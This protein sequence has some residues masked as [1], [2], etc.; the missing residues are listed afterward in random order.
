MKH[1]DYREI[2]REIADL[3]AQLGGV[4][5]MADAAFERAHPNQDRRDFAM[6][7][8]GQL[9][10]LQRESAVARDREQASAQ[11]VAQ[12]GEPL[13][14]G[15][16]GGG[17]GFPTFR[18]ALLGNFT[19]A[20]TTGSDG[21]SLV[22]APLLAEIVDKA[23]ASDPINRLARRF[24]LSG[25]SSKMRLP[26]RT[27]NG[28][29]VRVAEEEARPVTT[30][31]TFIELELACFERYAHYRASRMWVESTPDAE[32]LIIDMLTGDLYDSLAV[33]WAVGTG[34]AQPTGLFTNTAGANAYQV[35]FASIAG[36]ID[37]AQIIAAYM[38]LK[39]QYRAAAVWLM[40]SA[41]LAGF[42]ALTMPNM[43]NTPLVTWDN[44]KPRILGLPVEETTNAP[45]IGTATIPVALAD[46]A[47]AYAIGSHLR[48]E[49]GIHVEQIT[50]P[51]F[52]K[53]YALA[54]MGGIPWNKEAAILL[55]TALS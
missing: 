43:N 47:Q 5:K 33:D 22:P 19:A 3:E 13:D 35:K 51:Q 20:L 34:V 29:V 48:S 46:V 28:T 27:A 8:G 2:D 39:P 21:S 16:R 6:R 38:A 12:H 41:S 30:A 18:A 4:V 45:A 40:N 26:A 31:P 14:G 1:R 44:G 15:P 50:E 53:A 7:L 32:R 37:A 36:A 9:E 24:D 25:G 17:S 52:T 11:Y 49:I 23:R 55:S 42:T 10:A 54:R